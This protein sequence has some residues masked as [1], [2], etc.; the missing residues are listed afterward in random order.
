MVSSRY[1]WEAATTTACCLLWL[2]WTNG[3][4]TTT[5]ATTACLWSVL[6]ITGSTSWATLSSTKLVMI[7]FC[8]WVVAAVA[9]SVASLWLS[10]QK[11]YTTF[12]TYLALEFYLAF[13]LKTL[14]KNFPDFFIT[15]EHLGW[16]LL[17]YTNYEVIIY[18]NLHNELFFIIQIIFTIFCLIYIWKKLKQWKKLKTCLQSCLFKCAKRPQ[19]WRENSLR[20]WHH[21]SVT[22]FLWNC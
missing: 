22:T 20:L 5:V 6:L 11:D 17:W 19:I 2:S 10:L 4:T 14:K 18:F 16:S 8:L 13:N 3:A 15:S 12:S 7:A 21:L 1:V 9:E